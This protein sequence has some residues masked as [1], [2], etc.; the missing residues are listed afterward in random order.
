MDL[1]VRASL[2]GWKFVYLGDLQKIEF[3]KKL[4]V[5]Y[6]S[7]FVQKIIASMITFFFYCVVLPLTIFIPEVEAPVWGSF[8]IPSIIAILTSVGTPRIHLLE[9][10]FG[11]FLFTCACYDYMYGKHHYYVYLFLQVITFLI[12]GFGCIGIIVP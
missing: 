5:I 8:Y 10:G 7:F 11:V 12:V 6:S 1:A 3:W 2:C 4:H 9:L